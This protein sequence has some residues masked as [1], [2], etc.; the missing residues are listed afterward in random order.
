[1]DE[2]DCQDLLQRIGEGDESAAETLLDRYVDRLIALARSRLSPKIAR[3]LDPE[4]I[5]QSACRSFFRRTRADG[6]KVRDADGLW[7]LLATITVHKALRQ[8]KRQKA[9]KRSVD[10]EESIGR[11]GSLRGIPPEAISREPTPDQS[12][13]LIEVTQQMMDRLTTKQ[14]TVVLLRLQGYTV[15][16]TARQAGCS[17]RS[18]H[19]A[20][21]VAREFLEQRLV[22]TT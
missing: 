3:R 14:R 21:E 11:E 6:L 22:E 12:A 4:D 5:V 18:V 1:M 16:E 7:R 2:H 15:P 9:Q 17:E 8:V 20:M 13:A 10:A 19:R